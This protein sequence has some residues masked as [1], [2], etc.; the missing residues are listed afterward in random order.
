VLEVT[1]EGWDLKVRAEPGV[2]AQILDALWPGDRVLWKGEKTVKPNYTWYHVETYGGRMAYIAY[3]PEWVVPRDPAQTTPGIG[4]GVTVHVTQAGDGMHL[5]SSAGILS[6]EVKTL[7]LNETLTVLS[8]P[9]YNDFFLWW[10][11]RTADGRTGWAVD[12]PG[13][14]GVQ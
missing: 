6:G 4:V 10:E 3:K 13:W 12:V 9:V 5:R 1:A 2:K 8:G 7:G 11:L 14:W